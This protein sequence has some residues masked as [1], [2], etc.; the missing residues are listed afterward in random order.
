MIIPLTKGYETIVSPEDY[1]RL[2]QYF[3][4]VQINHD[5]GIYAK[6]T[7]A[8][9]KI[10]MHRLI[11]DCPPQFHVDHKDNN[12]LNNTRE[13]LRVVNAGHNMQNRNLPRGACPF[14]GVVIVG[15]RFRARINV[16][17]KVTSLGYYAT[18]DEAARVYDARALEEFGPFAKVNFPTEKDK[19]DE[20]PF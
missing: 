19:P 9:L 13:N 5:G 17:G 8:G 3:W 18:A 16:N 15:R 7:I 12:G 6:S 2:T 20:P 4:Q 10:Y 14:I 1:E 11:T